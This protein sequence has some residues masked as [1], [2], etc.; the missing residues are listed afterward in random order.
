MF[1]DGRRMARQVIFGCTMTFNLKSTC[2]Y[3]CHQIVPYKLC[4]IITYPIGNYESYLF[5][6]LSVSFKEF[7]CFEMIFCLM[8]L[9]SLIS[10]LKIFYYRSYIMQQSLNPQVNFMLNSQGGNTYRPTDSSIVSSRP[11]YKQVHF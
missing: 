3:Y 5:F 6:L 4:V 1:I 10:L 7:E 2:L 11:S 8:A 9:I